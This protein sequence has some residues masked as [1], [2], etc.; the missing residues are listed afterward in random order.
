MDL[1]KYIGI[2]EQ[3][4]PLK[5]LGIFLKYINTLDFEDAAVVGNS[6]QSVIRKDIRNTQTKPLSR[7]SSSMTEVHWQN[8][9]IGTFAKT[10]SY[11]AQ[12][13]GSDKNFINDITDVQ[14]LKYKVGGFYKY[15]V[16][17]CSQ[18]PRTLSGIFLLNNDYEGGELSFRNLDKTS[19]EIIPVKP[20]TIIVWPSNFLFPHKVK[21]V[22]K[23]T[24]YSVVAWGL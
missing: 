3:V 6:K 4:F 24:R 1:K 19:E 8:L 13:F 21:P 18:N 10:F 23:G 11:Y 16:D 22:K 12:S 2:Y 17:H 7:H 20:N 15:H 9:L 5:T 14:I